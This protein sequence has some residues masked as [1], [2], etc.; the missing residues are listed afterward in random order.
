MLSW[1][2]DNMPSTSLV[3]SFEAGAI[4]NSTFSHADHVFVIWHLIRRHGSLEAIRRFESSLKRITAESGHP[5]KYNAT[6]T[7]ALGFLLAERIAGEPSLEWDDFALRNRDL[8]KWP[9]EQLDRLYP[10]GSIHAERARR[11][12]MLPGA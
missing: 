1:Y 6:I 11:T 8:M 2:H 3:E 10:N 4:D 12:F 7:Y 5:E 9:N